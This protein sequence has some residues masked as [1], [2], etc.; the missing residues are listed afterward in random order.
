MVLKKDNVLGPGDRGTRVPGRY[1][2]PGDRGTRVSG[3]RSHTF[4]IF[5]L[6]ESKSSE[7]YMLIIATSIQIATFVVCWDCFRHSF[8]VSCCLLVLFK[9]LD[10]H[11]FNTF[12]L[13]HA[14]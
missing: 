1:K 5:Q 2:G 4:S 10:L 7:S 11:V 14:I 9:P 3:S 12:R 8:R 13:T 6:V